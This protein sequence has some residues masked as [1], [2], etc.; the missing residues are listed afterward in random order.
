MTYARIHNDYIGII[1]HVDIVFIFFYIKWIFMYIFRVCVCVCMFTKRIPSRYSCVLKFFSTFNKWKKIGNPIRL[2][3]KHPAY[4][5]HNSSEIPYWPCC[6]REQSKNSMIWMCYFW[7]LMQNPFSDINSINWASMINIDSGFDE[8][9]E[10][11]RNYRFHFHMSNT[12]W[13]SSSFIDL[14]IYWM[15]NERKKHTT[16]FSNK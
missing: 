8:R 4:S 11:N 14:I 9:S 13:S 7:L 12:D 16:Y 3:W 5:Q 10:K 1:E 15:K 2:K 6:M